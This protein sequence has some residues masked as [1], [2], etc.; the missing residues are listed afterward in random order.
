VTTLVRLPNW[1]GDTVL[2]LPALEGLAAVG[3]PLVLAGRARPIEL[4][5]HIVPEA[6][7]LLLRT[8]RGAGLS[9]GGTVRALRGMRIE[10]AVL[11][12][13]SFSSA[14]CAWSAGIAARIGWDEQ[15]RG[16][17]LTRR[18][19]R[20]ARGMVHICDEFK[21][22]ARAAGAGS[23]PECPVL[24]PDPRARRAAQA[25]LGKAC[26]HEPTGAREPGARPRLALCPGV[27]YGW[28]KQWPA[29]R[30]REV[31]ALAEQRGWSGI[32]LGAAE[33][34]ELARSVLTGAGPAWVSACGAGSLR[35][36]AEALRECDAAVCN[37]TGT[38]HLAA[39]VGTPVVALFG[40]SEPSWTG[41]RAHRA[42]V[43][44]AAC[45]CA[46]CYR[47]TCP[48]GRPAPCM[49]AIEAHAVVRAVEDL[50]RA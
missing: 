47:R 2:A 30:F 12:T 27:Q 41:P 7:R 34:A 46:P 36:A 33:E 40:P 14:L 20:A 4:T 19:P 50:I 49:L 3:A 10:R 6:R 18:V 17:L 23:F 42:Q 44:R 32:V 13:P 28:A 24:P 29:E 1:V 35:F 39:A 8:G 48:Q 38:M 31:R 45:S 22:L 11:M 26:S 25:F 21:A 15:G 43:L 16:W 9:W 5:E 37:D